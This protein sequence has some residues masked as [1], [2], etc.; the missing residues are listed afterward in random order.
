MPYDTL[1]NDPQVPSSEPLFRP[2]R[3]VSRNLGSKEGD[4]FPLPNLAFSLSWGMEIENVVKSRGN[5]V[6][7]VIHIWGLLSERGN[8][9][10][11]DTFA[12]RCKGLRSLNEGHDGEE[13]VDCLIQ[14]SF[15]WISQAFQLLHFIIKCKSIG[16]ID[17]KKFR[18]WKSSASNSISSLIE[19]SDIPSER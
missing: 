18:L 3:L 9:C 19:E 10:F 1:S 16:I 14:E 2:R 12:E 6:A 8:N 11:V 13:I 5:F 15:D 17:K 4:L 7:H